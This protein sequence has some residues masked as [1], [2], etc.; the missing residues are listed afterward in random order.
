MGDVPFPTGDKKEVLEALKKNY[1]LL[2]LQCTKRDFEEI[3]PLDET[4]QK[5]IFPEVLFGLKSSKLLNEEF[6]KVFSSKNL[7]QFWL[8]D[9][10]LLSFIL[11]LILSSDNYGIIS[12]SGS[13]PLKRLLSLRKDVTKTAKKEDEEIVFAAWF[14]LQGTLEY[15]YIFDNTPLSLFSVD[16][17]FQRA[18]LRKFSSVLETGTFEKALLS[19]RPD[20]ENLLKSSNYVSKYL[21]KWFFF[22]GYKDKYLFSKNQI[23]DLF[24]TDSSGDLLMNLIFVPEAIENSRFWILSRGYTAWKDSIDFN[25]A[26]LGEYLK[27]SVLKT[28]LCLGDV[29]GYKKSDISLTG[30]APGVTL[31][32]YG[33]NELGIGEDVRT[34]FHSLLNQGIDCK[35]FSVQPPGHPKPSKFIEIETVQE[36]STNVALFCLPLVDYST[37]RLCYGDMLIDKRYNICFAPWEFSTWQDDYNFCFD[38]LNEVWA[39]SEFVAEGYRNSFRGP[40]KVMPLVV[41]GEFQRTKSREDFNIPQDKFVFMFIFDFNSTLLRKNPFGLIKA[42]QNAFSGNDS[43]RLVIKTLYKNV[44]SDYEKSFQEIIASDNRVI[45]IDDIM[46]RNDLMSF[47][48]CC[49]AYVSLHRSEGFGRTLAEAM[50]LG[51]PV[52]A[53]NFSGSC[54]FAK[55]E[56]AFLVEYDLVSVG[57]GNYSFVRD[58]KWAEP[59]MASAIGALK[60]VYAGGREVDEISRAGQELIKTKFSREYVGKIYSQ[61]VNEILEG[62]KKL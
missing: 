18:D 32:G 58:A 16:S 57:V 23:I 14:M 48:D 62:L 2:Y 54:E 55:K 9:E 25:L 45:V 51:K 4:F 38:G 56:T 11:K 12:L 6:Y 61:R 21:F 34:T 22:E 44:F 59:N 46:S 30:C 47:I 17:T 60:K 24:S 29:F 7:L 36:V 27:E 13:Y 43:V 31:I 53:T 37:L 41:D 20:L 33:R 3:H 8:R 5:E 28:P 42:F 19:K 40:V 52:V 15:R 10:S 1:P 50:L 49:D 26:L 35:L 39:S